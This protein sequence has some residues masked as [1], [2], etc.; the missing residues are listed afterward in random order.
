MRPLYVFES[1]VA[2]WLSILIVSCGDSSKPTYQFYE[3]NLLGN[4]EVFNQLSDRAIASGVD[5][6][7]RTSVYPKDKLGDDKIEW[8]HLMFK[9]L[10]VNGGL[11]VDR[12]YNL[13]ELIMWSSG[14]V[15]RG[16]MILL[17]RVEKKYLKLSFIGGKWKV[18]NCFARYYR[19]I[20]IFVLPSK[21]RPFN[22]LHSGRMYWRWGTSASCGGMATVAM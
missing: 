16:E 9:K 20:G 4:K 12:R 11:Q 7:S 13:V 8:F 21:W 15:N 17:V 2:F 14:I 19:M 18:T 10:G 3:K 22:L 6:I 1:I 5:R